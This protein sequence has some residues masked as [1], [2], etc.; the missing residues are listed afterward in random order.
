M[1]T[2]SEMMSEDLNA[3]EFWSELQA[4]AWQ[5]YNR[6]IEAVNA[7]QGRTV[8]QLALTM[9]SRGPSQQRG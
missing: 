2:P 5:E 9:N 1:L 3:I 6:Q 7:E 8:E 4:L